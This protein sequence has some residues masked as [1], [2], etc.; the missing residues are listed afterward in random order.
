M[1]VWLCCRVTVCVPPNPCPEILTPNVMVLGGGS[2][3]RWQGHESAALMSEISP[4]RKG[5]LRAPSSLPPCEDRPWEAHHGRHESATL[6]N[7]IS[8]LIKGPPR[9]PSSLPPCEDRSCEGH[10]RRLWRRKGCPQQALNL[11]RLWFMHVQAPEL[12]E[13]NAHFNKPNSPHYFLIT[14]ATD[15][16]QLFSP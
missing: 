7:E 16:D 9:A 13:I 12:R 1:S 3:T 15:Y 11:P 10:H 2:S 14:P 8:A 6:M 5:A 4:P